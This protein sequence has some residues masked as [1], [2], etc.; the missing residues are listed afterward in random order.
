MGTS[1]ISTRTA[2]ASTSVTSMPRVSTSTTTGTTTAT[3]TSVSRLPGSHNSIQKLETPTKMGV[4][5]IYIHGIKN[6]QGYI[7]E[8]GDNPLDY[9]PCGDSGKKLSAIV[10]CYNPA[11]VNSKERYDWISRNISNITEEAVRIRN[12]N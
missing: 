1:N 9:I 7:T 3:T 4:A 8:K 11:G 12:S 5:G 6:S 2:I 10:K